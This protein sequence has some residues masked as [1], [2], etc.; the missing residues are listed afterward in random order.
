[1][2]V[3]RWKNRLY[4]WMLPVFGLHVRL[5]YARSGDLP[6]KALKD[7]ERIFNRHLV[8]GAALQ[9]IRGGELGPLVVYGNAC[10]GRA[11]V[12][13][14]TIFR[15]AS[16]TKM[17]TAVGAMRLVERGVLDLQEPIE[18]YLGFPV[19]NPMHPEKPITLFQL[20]SHTSG[21]CDGPGYEQALRSPIPL[22]TLLKDQQSYI[23]AAPG[24][25]FRYSN[26]GAGMVGSVMERATGQSLEALMHELVFDPLEMNA[27]YTLAHWPDAYNVANIYR[28][29]P[30]RK[31][32]VF[33][34]D[35]RFETADPLAAPDPEHHYLIAAG[36][37]FTDAPSLGKLL[38]VLAKGGGPL[39]SAETIS[40]MKTPVAAYGKHAPFMRHGLGLAL[41]EDQKLCPGRVFGHQGFAY[42]AAEGVFY[43]EGT[44]NGLVFLNSGASELRRDNLACVNRDLIAWALGPQ[45]GRAWM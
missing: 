16:I 35:R 33:D 18:T 20:L 36:N 29:L 37:L 39:L 8:V 23:Q 30:A 24:E 38:C 14:Q 5:N 19:R 31:R 32:P 4:R 28:V 45:G 15:A 7:L 43:H 27:S 25:A 3:T 34:A 44:G 42:G 40:L 11:V 9:L 13:P 12:V 26:L 22:Q 21:I 17:V 1:M 41:M 2:P 6:S 10:L